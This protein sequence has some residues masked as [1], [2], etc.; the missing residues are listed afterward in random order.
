VVGKA[1]AA[2]AICRCDCGVEKTYIV[3]HL[4]SG[5]IRQ[6]GCESDA[7]T[8]K[9]TPPEKT[10]EKV[11]ALV[12]SPLYWVPAQGMKQCGGLTSCGEWKAL[13]EFGMN[14]T[15]EDGRHYY[16]LACSRRK[17]KKRDS[18]RWLKK[19][20]GITPAERDTLLAAQG[21]VC[22]RCAAEFADKRRCTDHDHECCPGR[23]S[24]GHCVR[25]VVCATCNSLLTVAYC[26]AH[27]TDPY[28]QRYAQRRAATEAAPSAA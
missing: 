7:P 10:P 20:F 3:R 23:R 12:P 26:R 2:R 1:H 5:A 6:C 15:Q 27:P 28:L 22:G 16:C 9:W 17:D 11:V 8:W 4:R 25:G 13:D 14:S 21:G 24:C 18:G 19:R